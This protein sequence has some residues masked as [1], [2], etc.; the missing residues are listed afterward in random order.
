MMESLTK[1][2]F[3][4]VVRVMAHALDALDIAV[5]ITDAQRQVYFTN[6]QATCL[7][8]GNSGLKIAGG[9]LTCTDPRTADNLDR[10]LTTAAGRVPQERATS[11]VTL[12]GWHL[13]TVLPLEARGESRRSRLKI[14]L[15]FTDPKMCPKSRECALVEAFALT[16]AEARVAMQVAAG[17]S[18]KEIA[19]RTGATHHTVRFQL[20]AIF[21]KTGT[22]RQSQLAR[23][24]SVIPGQ[25]EAAL[26][27]SLLVPLPARKV[28]PIPLVCSLASKVRT[29]SHEAT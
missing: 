28:R 29:L 22:S 5:I 26:P 10:L 25:L 23:L 3:R 20:K 8:N 27:K 18:A 2:D 17:M 19:Q 4:H 12:N 21:R 16:P 9:K 1:N 14:L 11:I 13:F 6:H 24:I 15:M 7:L